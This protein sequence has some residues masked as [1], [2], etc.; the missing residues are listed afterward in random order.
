MTFPYWV[1][2]GVVL[3]TPISGKGARDLSVRTGEVVLT[4]VWWEIQGCLSQV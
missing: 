2:G 4:G 1:C 3:V